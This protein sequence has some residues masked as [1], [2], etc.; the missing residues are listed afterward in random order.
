MERQP[1]GPELCE[2]FDLKLRLAFVTRANELR[3]EKVNQETQ[4]Q[5]MG[6]SLGRQI[7]RRAISEIQTRDTDGLRGIDVDSLRRPGVSIK[8]LAATLKQYR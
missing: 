4:T 7:W 3:Q 1:Y 5:T 8:L 2:W 6:R